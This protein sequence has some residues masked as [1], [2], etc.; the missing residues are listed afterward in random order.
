MTA[1][2]NAP[3]ARNRLLDLPGGETLTYREMVRAVF[4]SL[5]KRPIL[6]YHAPRTRPFRI[7]GVA[8]GVGSGVQRGEPRTD[9]QRLSPSTRA[10]CATCSESPAGPFA[11]SFPIPGRHPKRVACGRLDPGPSGPP[12]PPGPSAS[13]VRGESDEEHRHL[14]RRTGNEYGR[15]NTNVVETYALVEKGRDQV[16]WYDPGVGTGGWEYEEEKGGLR[17]KA[18]LMT[19]WGLQRN[20]EDA[21]RRLMQC[22]E[23]GDRVYLFG[24]SRGAFTVRSLAGMLRKCG[25]LGPGHENL[26]EYASRIYNTKGNEDIRRRGSGAPSGATA[27][28]SSSGSGTPSIHWR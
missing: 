21:Y 18:D 13:A 2:L 7:P 23:S 27:R 16:A 6:I 26:V 20:V 9:E 17:A 5:G 25:L 14:L 8:G 1:A 3:G 12:G 28:S 24:F 11:P 10:R 4:R 22:H 19:G 15:N